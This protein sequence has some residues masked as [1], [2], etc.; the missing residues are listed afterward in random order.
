MFLEYFGI[1][2]NPDKHFNYSNKVVLAD[3]SGL[4]ITIF[5]IF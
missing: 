3:D 1:K 5:L 2:L 4:L